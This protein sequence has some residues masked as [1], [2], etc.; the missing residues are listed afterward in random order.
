V[1]IEMRLIKATAAEQLRDLEQAS[2]HAIIASGLALA[3]GSADQF[4]RCREVEAKIHRAAGD[5][6]QALSCQQ[7]AIARATTDRLRAQLAIKAWQWA[8]RLDLFRRAT[9]SL[10]QAEQHPS[11][12]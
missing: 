6:W 5:H 9:S 3:E 1:R 7:D 4:A 10:Q 2:R 8:S 12:D 11:A